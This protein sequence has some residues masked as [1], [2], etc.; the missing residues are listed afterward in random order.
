MTIT[1]AIKA[2]TK[3]GFTVEKNGILYT[4][5]K[6]GCKNVVE[7]MQNG[8]EDIITC[9]GIRSTND[10]SDSMIDYCATRFCRSLKQAIQLA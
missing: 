3:A 7:F 8:R 2:V 5:S 10:R 4:A 1:N 9:V 6:A